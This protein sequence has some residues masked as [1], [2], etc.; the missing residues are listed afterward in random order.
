MN[1]VFYAEHVSTLLARI[2]FSVNTWKKKKS[3]ILQ[4]KDQHLCV[5]MWFH[6]IR[7]SVSDMVVNHIFSPRLFTHCSDKFIKTKNLLTDVKELVYKA[8]YGHLLLIN[9]VHFFLVIFFFSLEV[10]R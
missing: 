3:I 7:R 9:G 2:H 4:Q 6:S 1:L 8:V 10:R 5:H